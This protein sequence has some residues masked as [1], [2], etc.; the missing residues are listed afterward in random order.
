MKRKIT[1]EGIEASKA[2]EWV[3]GDWW[4]T[5]GW[6]VGGGTK[7]R[8]GRKKRGMSVVCGRL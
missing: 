8:S 3:V 5:G 7:G 2:S 6:E 1:D 4:V